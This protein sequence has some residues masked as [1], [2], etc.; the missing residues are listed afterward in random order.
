MSFSR[1]NP[2]GWNPGD[3]L[4]AIHITQIDMNQ[5]RAVD[6]FAGGSYAP[7]APLIFPGTEGVQISK[8]DLLAGGATAIKH[9]VTLTGADGAA[10]AL[11][12]DPDFLPAIRTAGGAARTIKRVQPAMLGHSPH[13]N[14]WQR[15]SVAGGNLLGGFGG[16]WIQTSISTVDD[17]D[18]GQLWIPISN[19][20][21]L[22]SLVSVTVHLTGKANASVA[23]HSNTPQ[24]QPTVEVFKVDASATPGPAITSLSSQVQDNTA[25]PGYDAPHTIV[26]ALTSPEPIDQS[27]SDPETTYF[28]VVTGEHGSNAVA[29]TTSVFA[30]EASF[31]VTKLTPG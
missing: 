26:C 19:L 23:G 20:I 17:P 21:D 11:H 3:I 14:N 31:S 2:T 28:V 25:H 1:V 10:I 24:N 27:G 5:S 6:G 16:S 15:D 12:G 18:A 7:S 29:N 22:A 9:P 30:C 8:F 4:K 13:E